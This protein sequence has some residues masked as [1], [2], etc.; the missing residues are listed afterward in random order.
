M[1]GDCAREIQAETV[2]QNKIPKLFQKAEIEHLSPGLQVKIEALAESKGLLLWGLPGVGKSYA[3]CAIAKGLI[4]QGKGVE[5]VSYEMLCLKIRDTYKANTTKG[6]LDV[7]KPLCEVENLIVEDVG[8][9]VS[10][11]QQESDFS[12]RTFLVLLDQRLEQCRPTFITT[13][14]SVEELV[15]SFDARIASRIQQA[16]EVVQLSGDDR[17]TINE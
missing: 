8:V 7:I 6:E 13:N 1:C 9:T 4:R 14:R 10:A 11:G 5:R 12:R 17:R 16:C 2:I 3:M 15:K